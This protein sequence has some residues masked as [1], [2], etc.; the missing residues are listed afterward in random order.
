[1]PCLYFLFLFFLISTLERILEEEQ[2]PNNSY[3]GKIREELR[4]PSQNVLTQSVPRSRDHYTDLVRHFVMLGFLFV[5]DDEG[6][7]YAPQ[8]S[9]SLARSISVPN[10][11]TT[12]TIFP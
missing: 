10:T 12:D 3:I 9:L 8:C 5:F 6:K 4:Q 7:E 1:M 11:N 2:N